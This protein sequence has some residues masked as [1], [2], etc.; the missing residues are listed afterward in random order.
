MC[1]LTIRSNP[2]QTRASLSF[3]FLLGLL[4][5]PVAVFADD[6]EA[7]PS[8]RTAGGRGCEKTSQTSN[9]NVP[10]VILLT[11]QGRSST[12]STRPTFAWFVRD[13]APVSME[14]RLYSKT[15]MNRYKLIREIKDDRFQTVPG[16]MI[17]S[18]IQT[19]PELKIGQYRWQV[20]LVCD[21][22]HPSSN[23]F[24]E[25]ELDVVP[26][27]L[28]LKTQLEKARDPFSQALLYVQASYWY[29]A[30]R[31]TASSSAHNTGDSSRLYDPRLAL[32][33]QVMLN[34]AERQLIQNSK[35]HFIQR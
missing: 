31:T 33:D 34:N 30:L 29:D 1:D 32:L 6:D 22:S 35:V 10:S 3:I 16:I 27:P 17:L 8:G 21:R 25:S 5:T 11:P 19:T 23:L 15:E 20:V 26:M 24:A 13:A 9:S 2:N 28:E 4:L 12:V 18:T 7:P 14:F